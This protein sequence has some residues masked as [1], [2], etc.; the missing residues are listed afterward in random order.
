MFEVSIRRQAATI[1]RGHMETDQ[2]AVQLI[3][4]LR[5]FQTITGKMT[6]NDDDLE[7]LLR[8]ILRLMVSMLSVSYGSILLLE[9]RSKRFRTYVTHGEFPLP[10]NL[11]TASDATKIVRCPASSGE[12]LVFS[13]FV[14][15]SEWERLSP[16]N[17][18]ILG[19]VLCSPLIVN[20]QV[21]GLACVYGSEFDPASLESEMFCL[22]ASLAAIAIEKSRLYWEVQ[23]KLGTVE[24]ELKKAQ[25]QLIRSEKLNS[26]AE[27]AMSVSHFIRN[28]V[29]V[30]GG[31]VRRMRREFSDSDPKQ[32]WVDMILSE[33]SRLEGFV[34]DFKR[35]VSLLEQMSFKRADINRIAREAAHDFLD[36]CGQAER[37]RLALRIYP[38]PLFCSVDTHLLKRSLLHLLTNAYEASAGRAHITIITSLNGREATIS[39]V[40]AGRGMSREEMNHIFDPFFTTKGQGAGMGLTSVHFIVTEHGGRVEITSERGVGSQFRIRLP[41]DQKE[42]A[43]P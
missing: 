9:T 1:I 39:V 34:G 23:R 22:I 2:S 13:E 24:S 11:R 30:I 18:A 28:P 32:K 19:K 40:D 16:E 8:A 42:F 25:S 12:R 31:L 35:G 7:Q 4:I 10:L 20:Q 15:A 17:R 26:L 33:V 21:I 41:I 5:S 43:F 38:E 37:I 14:E 36:R 3:E 29:T 27:I 6:A